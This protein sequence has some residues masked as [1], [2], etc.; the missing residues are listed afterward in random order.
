LNGQTT[1]E[2]CSNLENQRI[3][4]KSEVYVGLL[5]ARLSL[6]T[7]ELDARRREH[8]SIVGELDKSRKIGSE[9]KKKL[10]SANANLLR[11]QQRHLVEVSRLTSMLTDGQ[12]EE[13]LH[14]AEKELVNFHSFSVLHI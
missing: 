6:L 10:S 7:K 2:A 3:D 4:S 14:I 1:D 11:C 5:V 12:K 8:S 9:L 13:L